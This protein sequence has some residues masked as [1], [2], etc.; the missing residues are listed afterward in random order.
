MKRAALVSRQATKQSETS[1]EK[2][3]LDEFTKRL[4]MSLV[5]DI[6]QLAAGVEQVKVEVFT[7]AK[8]HGVFTGV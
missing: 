7:L 3:D 5:F 8:A 4:L 1:S 6:T 2:D